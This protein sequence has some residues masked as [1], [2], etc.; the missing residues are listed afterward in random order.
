MRRRETGLVLFALALLAVSLLTETRRDVSAAGPVAGDAARP[1][2]RPRGEAAALDVDEWL[3]RLKA[4]GMNNA[5]SGA[6]LF[7]G[8]SW[9]PQPDPAALQAP[10]KPVTPPFPFI[11]LG[12]MKLG[13]AT[14]VV[15]AKG[16]VSYTVKV[17]E[18]I[19]QFRVDRID[20][21]G[22]R[23]TYVPTSESRDYRYEQLYAAVS[24]APLA[25]S[26][27]PMQQPAPPMQQPADAPQLRL[28]VPASPVPAERPAGNAA[29]T[30]AAAAIAAGTAAGNTNTPFPFNPLVQGAAAPI[31]GMVI[32]PAAPGSGMVITPTPPGAAMAITPP[33]AGSGMVMVQPPPGIVM[34]G[35]S[36]VPTGSTSA[37]AAQ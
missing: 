12:R 14:F 34:P 24:A 1:D 31:G 20:D 13:D 17:G 23:V 7:G 29:I 30:G 28:P 11:L 4:R 2:A 35:L 19:E 37:P 21:D 15:V 6:G 8:T 27:M 9:Q 16:D 33:Q 3:A 32:N 22:L 5:P 25:G 18:M 36:G 26:P 10:A